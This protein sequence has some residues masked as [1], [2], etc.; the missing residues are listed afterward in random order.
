VTWEKPILEYVQEGNT[1]YP[2]SENLINVPDVDWTYWV[3][4]EIP[5]SVNGAHLDIPHPIH[6]HG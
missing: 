4:Q 2:H 6:L 1:S 5:T 3:L